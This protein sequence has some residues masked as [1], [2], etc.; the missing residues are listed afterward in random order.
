MVSYRSDDHVVHTR[1]RDLPKFLSPGDV[2]VINTSGTLNAALHATRA[3][4]MALELHL[5]THLPGDVWVVEL[6][7]PT[8][9][10]TVPFNQAGDGEVVTLPGGGQA[11]L[12]APLAESANRLWIASLHLPSPLDDYLARY[13]FPIH[14]GYVRENWPLS[15]YQTAY[16]TEPG[17][18][19]MPSA[20][21]P[22]TPE[23]ITRL[24]ARGVQIVP[25]ILHTGV[26]SL[27]SHEA[28]YDE[29]YAVPSETADAVNSAR[30]GGKRVIAVGTTV[31]RALET[32]T[33]MEGVTWRGEGWTRLVVTPR[34]G[35]RAVNGL[36]T[37]L[38]EPRSSHLSMLEALVG[39]A[40]LEITYASALR[41]H[42]LWHE[43]GDVH[44]ILPFA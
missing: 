34:R 4:G 24:V 35:I 30:A 9:R 14:Y 33:D 37:G 13:G 15:Y 7:R 29:Y 3:D 21:R 44:L 16:V 20:G 41:E 10:G 8:E 36:L 42:Y 17:S 39:R 27:E 6:R 19:E 23:L 1:F 28:P 43:F 31:V 26:S 32:V 12:Q 22:F 11:T 18:A 25:L 40:H 2:L 38:H 5:S